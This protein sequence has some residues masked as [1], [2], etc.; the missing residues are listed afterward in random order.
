M[1]GLMIHAENR[2]H[3]AAVVVG[4]QVPKGEDVSEAIY[5]SQTRKKNLIN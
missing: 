3:H 4:S 2:S 5:I 1:V